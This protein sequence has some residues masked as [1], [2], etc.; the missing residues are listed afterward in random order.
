MLLPCYSINIYQTCYDL[1]PPFVQSE[2]VEV[3]NVEHYAVNGV[4]DCP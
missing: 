4:T 1:S 3:S 2:G